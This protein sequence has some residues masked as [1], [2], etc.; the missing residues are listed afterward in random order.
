MYNQ[1]SVLSIDVKYNLNKN[2]NND[3]NQEL[4][5]LQHS[6]KFLLRQLKAKL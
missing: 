5:N 2:E 4:F 6:M 1:E 3:D